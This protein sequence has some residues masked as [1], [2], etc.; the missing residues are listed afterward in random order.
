MLVI[1]LLFAEDCRA[2]RRTRQIPQAMHL[3]YNGL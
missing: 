3:P 2:L 1:V